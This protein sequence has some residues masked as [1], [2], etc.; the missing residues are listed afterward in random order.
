MDLIVNSDGMSVVII[1]QEDIHF[2]N[3]RE[4]ETRILQEIAAGADDIVLDLSN[5]GTLYSMTLGMFNNIAMSV[6][7][8]CGTFSLTN[9]N[10][11][12]KKI[13][14]ATRLDKVIPIR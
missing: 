5:V 7:K 9:V 6:A 8:K 3:Y 2:D 14:K 13:M 11:D 1:P 12:I 4:V 10:P